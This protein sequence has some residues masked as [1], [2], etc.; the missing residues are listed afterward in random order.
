MQNKYL[1]HLESDNLDTASK[2]NLDA[3]VYA[4]TQGTSEPFL[5]DLILTLRQS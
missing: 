1:R 2:G 3:L 4:N 5:F